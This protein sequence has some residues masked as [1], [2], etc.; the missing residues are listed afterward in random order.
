MV[1]CAVGRSCA[2]QS[3]KPRRR[4]AR[5]LTRALRGALRRWMPDYFDVGSEGIPGPSTFAA[6]T[7]GSVG[8]AAALFVAMIGYCRQKR[9]L[10][11]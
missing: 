7:V 4:P 8:G 1:S 11:I 3:V 10:I 6:I 2:A 5:S 9:L